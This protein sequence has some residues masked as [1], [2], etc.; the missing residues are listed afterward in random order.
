MSI[1]Q[2]IQE[3][4]AELAAG[5]DKRAARV[6]TDAIYRTHDPVL[7]N[8]IRMVATE[9]RAQAGRFGK[10]RW[11]AGGSAMVSYL[12]ST[13]SVSFSAASTGTEKTPVIVLCRFVPGSP[14]FSV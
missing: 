3:A 11:D 2:S 7:G 10:G 8:E 12:R 14:T 6:L 5:H 9:G 1:E 13:V 4:K